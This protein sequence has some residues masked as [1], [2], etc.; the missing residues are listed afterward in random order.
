MRVK[1]FSLAIY[2]QVIPTTNVSYI[3]GQGSGLKAM[4]SF[5]QTAQWNTLSVTKCVPKFEK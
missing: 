2:A 4:L 1:S 3:L 5:L